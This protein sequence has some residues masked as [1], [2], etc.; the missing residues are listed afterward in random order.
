[1]TELVFPQGEGPFSLPAAQ[2]A[3]AN[4]RNGLVVATFSV[5]VPSRG[6]V[7]VRVDIAMTPTAARLLAETLNDS[8]DDAEGTRKE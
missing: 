6:L 8:A 5:V 1:M 7:P 3:V 2:G 4:A